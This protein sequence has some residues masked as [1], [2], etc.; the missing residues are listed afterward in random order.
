MNEQEKTAARRKDR[1]AQ[2]TKN[3]IKDALLELLPSHPFEKL[4]VSAVCKQA[5]IGRATFY[6][7]YDGLMDVVDE[8]ADDAIN[9][10]NA[11]PEDIMAG[12]DAML[13][14]MKSSTSPDELDPHLELLPICQ[15]VADNPKYRV[16]FLDPALSQYMLNRIFFRESRKLTPYFMENYNLSKNQALMLSRF[17]MYGAFAVNEAMNW[18]KDEEWYQVQQVLLSFLSGGYQSLKR[19]KPANK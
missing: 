7:H 19:L 3:I 6:L 4:S 1:R 17:T 2:Y 11:G 10:T 18:K 13:A 8:L 15:R 14:L 12:M 9:N 16:M 5:E